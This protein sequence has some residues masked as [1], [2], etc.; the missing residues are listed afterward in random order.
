MF[1]E[2][3]KCNLPIYWASALINDDW[4]GLYEEDTQALK[5]WLE[6]N[7]NLTCMDVSEDYSFSSYH[8]ASDI[9]PFGCDVAEYIFLHVD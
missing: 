8:D 5:Q 1:D 2:T 4:S 6:I 7:A 9:Y 3:I